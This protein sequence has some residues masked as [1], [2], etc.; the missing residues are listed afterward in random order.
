MIRVYEINLCLAHLWCLGA[1]FAPGWALTIF[2]LAMCGV[3]ALAASNAL[4]LV[5]ESR[6]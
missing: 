6:V 5:R 3:C 2:C 4:R 1:V